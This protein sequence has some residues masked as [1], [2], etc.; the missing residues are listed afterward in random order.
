MQ[1]KSD[2]FLVL[3]SVA[4]LCATLILIFCL[5]LNLL[6]FGGQLLSY[7]L[8]ILLLLGFSLI[9]FRARRNGGREIQEQRDTELAG[10]REANAVHV[11]TIE[12]LAIAIDAKD[13]TTHGHIRRS[14]V[15]AVEMGKLLGVSNAEIAALRTGAI[16][17]DIGKLA[18]P[19]FILNKPGK[20]TAAEFDRMKI[21]TIVGADIIKGI[22]LPYPVEQ[23][24]RFHHERWDGS[25]YPEGLR[26]EEIPLLARIISVVDFYDALRCDRPYRPGMNRSEA[27]SLLRQSA[28][29]LFDPLVVTKFAENVFDFDKLIQPEDLREQVRIEI[30]QQPAALSKV[31]HQPDTNSS[32][33][34]RPVF[35]SI[36]DAQR[37]V[38]ALRDIAQ[39][40]GCSLNLQDTLSLISAK[41]R[42]IVPY[43]LCIVYLSDDANR[44][45][46]AEYV[47]G[48]GAEAF[49]GRILHYGEG[50][51]GWVISN[52]H[53]MCSA[54]PE[55]DFAGLAPESVG[56][57]HSALVSP[58]LHEK[59][60]IGAIALYSGQPLSYGSEQLTLLEAI[61]LHAASAISNALIFEK[62]RDS[63]LNDPV[64]G[65]SNE[66]ALRLILDQ[67]VAECRR[68]G[69]DPL[70]LLCI[71][72]DN[73]KDVNDRFGHA[74]GD[75]M[76]SDLGSLIR[77]QLR[78]MDILARWTADEFVAVMPTATCETAAAVAER[79]RLAVEAHSFQVRTGRQMTINLSFGISSFPKNGDTTEHLLAAANED[80]RRTKNFPDTTA[81]KKI[82]LA[83]TTPVE[84]HH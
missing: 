48:E 3:T 23:I 80:L 37:E 52:S 25:G 5:G 49:A 57:I 14:Q 84:T 54:N 6:T 74:A 75:R 60:A 2:K 15:Y 9:M 59:R 77:K 29:T 82:S 31:E 66:R 32:T 26:G 43:D 1:L 24:A 61:S 16:L 4:I 10:L 13:R 38:A 81:H 78:Q 27:I 76:L 65:L 73:F 8:N 50:V 53:S 56:R 64:T 17:H 7:L 45:I 30:T 83:A 12:S 79:I 70:S 41:L 55:L 46:R 22:E 71:N 44:R 36:A 20:L 72:I 62:T 28:G 47:E 18:V 19:E 21:H 11:R 35:K 33:D 67:R 69:R 39:T 51:A 58:L 63:A 68:L 34:A 40:I 42:A